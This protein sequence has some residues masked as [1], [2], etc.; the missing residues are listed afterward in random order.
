MQKRNEEILKRAK[1]YFKAICLIG[2]STQISCTST[3]DPR[4]GGIFWSRNKALER[5]DDLYNK[6]Q[7]LIK[8][9]SKEAVN[10]RQLKNELASQEKK[11]TQ[12]KQSLAA[13]CKTSDS[14]EVAF[15]NQQIA[16]LENEILRKKM[17]IIAY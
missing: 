9:N 13:A 2:I 8:D 11:L 7:V 4:V 15:L 16:Q 10:Q 3:G 1:K 17:L 12:L 5:Q 6:Q 14:S